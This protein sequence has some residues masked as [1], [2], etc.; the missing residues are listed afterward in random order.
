MKLVIRNF[1]ILIIAIPT[2][3]VLYYNFV[4]NITNSLCI[5]DTDFCQKIKYYLLPTSNSIL[6]QI[7]ISD[8]WIWYNGKNIYVYNAPVS[9]L[10]CKDPK[11]YEAAYVV[12]K[13]SGLPGGY[14]CIK[15]LDQTI[16]FFEKR[17]SPSYVFLREF[18][19]T[20]SAYDVMKY[21]ESQ[22]LINLD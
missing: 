17:T 14:E 11:K 9:D 3:Y 4:K 8:W 2:A 22:K 18:D 1:I 7:P 21:F 12:D 19:E 10:I 6:V 20:F 13:K 5:T 16:A 15:R